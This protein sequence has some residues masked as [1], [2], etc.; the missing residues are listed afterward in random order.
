MNQS[1]NSIRV[2]PRVGGGAD[3]V[4]V[5]ASARTVSRGG[6]SCL[7]LISATGFGS[8]FLRLTTATGFGVRCLRLS[9]ATGFRGHG[10]DFFFGGV[11]AA[12]SARC[13]PKAVGIAKTTRVATRKARARCMDEEKFKRRSCQ[14][15]NEPDSIH[16][17]DLSSVFL[18]RRGVDVD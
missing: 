13:E 8:R 7:C 12:A 18:E 4:E 6:S 15:V 17:V 14:T 10:F 5:G 2:G 9:S 3:A 1:S 11:R 16:C